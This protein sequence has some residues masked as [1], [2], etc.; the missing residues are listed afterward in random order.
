MEA[1][2][3]QY[4]ALARYNHWMNARLYGVAGE[5]SDEERTRDLGAFFRSVHGTLNHLL[6][7]DRAWLAR[8]TGD[9]EL[10]TVTS[11]SGERIAVRALDQELFADFGEL[12][13][14]REET[15]ALIETWVAGLTPERL[16]GPIAYRDSK[17]RAHEHPLWWAVGH[18]FNHQTHHRG[19]VTTL[20]SQLGRDPGVTDLVAMLREAPPGGDS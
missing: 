20:L 8:F 16:A 17:G 13:R 14:V 10:A 11:S 18:F 1:A 6:L 19:Q 2:L 4:R 3:R 15:D 9:R 5:L 12:R 7:T